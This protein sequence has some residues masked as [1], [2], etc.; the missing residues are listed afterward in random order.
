LIALIID[1]HHTPIP[2]AED[3]ALSCSPHPEKT[4]KD[5]I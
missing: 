2:S 1:V 4:G 3:D 5:S